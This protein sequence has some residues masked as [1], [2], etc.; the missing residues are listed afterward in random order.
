MQ[1]TTKIYIFL[2]VH[3]R[4]FMFAKLSGV[5]FSF[6]DDNNTDVKEDNGRSVN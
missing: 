5:Q 4:N 6:F 1:S 2:C 3:R